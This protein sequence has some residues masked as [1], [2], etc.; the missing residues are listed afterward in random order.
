MAKIDLAVE[1]G[2]YSGA[3]CDSACFKAM[4]RK[5]IAQA[6]FLDQ[7]KYFF[8]HLFN[9]NDWPPRW[10][11]GTWSDF[12]GWLYIISDVAI[13]AAYFAIPFLLFRI[14]KKRKDIPFPRV[15][16]LFI[17]FILFCGITHLL[18]AIIF[19]WPVYRVSALTRFFTAVVSII[20]VGALY[21]ILPFIYSLRTLAELEVE[22]EERKK[23]EA[24]AHKHQLKHEAAMELMAKKDEFMSIASHELKTPVTSV[25]AT[26]Q[27]LEKVVGKSDELK[28]LAP[29]V[30]RASKQVGKLTSIIS[31]LIDVAA[32]QENRLKLR[33]S[34]FNLLELVE[35]CAETCR[36]ANDGRTVNITGDNTIV[37][38][39]DYH[40][41]EQVLCNLL[42]NAFKYSAAS[43]PVDITF[44]MIGQDRVKI[45]VTD[46]GIGIP[47]DK[48]P[49]V[50]DRFF[51]VEE[52][53]Q[54]YSGIGL[55]LYIS[56]EI[57]RIHGGT[58]GLYSEVN[59][60]S[61]FW[62]EIPLNAKAQT[63]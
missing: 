16:W 2:L 13:W 36:F 49:L 58:I 37:V 11:C 59:V 20:T 61:T 41:L 30:S 29:Y 55:G 45:S 63:V 52:T 19:W 8:S 47:E 25:K 56:S 51:R 18:D 28:E 62:F 10:H 57:V 39:A 12:H 15:L 26:L 33:F 46:H 23:A 35:E 48:A 9:T 44:R 40:R 7:V 27:M 53:S 3:K 22:I 42:T 17:L 60:G 6:G 14:V 31:E 38:F 5:D 24:E 1:K 34:E 54:N 50:F 21:K 43:E 32:I 4:P